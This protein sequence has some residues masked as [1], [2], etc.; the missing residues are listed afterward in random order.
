MSA[1]KEGNYATALREWKPPAEG[2]NADSQFYLGQLHEYGKGVPMGTKGA[3]KW[4]ELAT[5]KGLQEAQENLKFLIDQE[6]QKIVREKERIAR[7]KRK[8]PDQLLSSALVCFNLN[9]LCPEFYS[10][11]TR[12][13]PDG[14]S[15]SN[16]HPSQN[17][18]LDL[19]LLIDETV[20]SDQ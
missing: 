3:R 5:K 18:D 14:L 20:S 10:R 8:S 15:G 13:L 1:F 6:A 4:Y 12:R 19:L 17:K 7:E 11:S 16:G 9:T 2:V